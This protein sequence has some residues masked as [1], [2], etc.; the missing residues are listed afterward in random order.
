MSFNLVQTALL[1]ATL[2]TSS[3]ALPVPTFSSNTGPRYVGHEIEATGMKH[4]TFR[5]STEITR[6]DCNERSLNID[7]IRTGSGGIGY[8]DQ[9]LVNTSVVW[10]QLHCP[11]DEPITET[12][13]SE[14]FVLESFYNRSSVQYE[15]ISEIILPEGYELILQESNSEDE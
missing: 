4:L 7:V 9:Y 11:L 13:T 3:I 6:D 10:L 1:V 12:I 15:F 2:F 5:V 14:S 8:Y